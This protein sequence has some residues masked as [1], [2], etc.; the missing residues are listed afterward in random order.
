MKICLL[1]P[2]FPFPENGG[3]VL[4]LN[5]I[6]RYLKNKG[7]ELILISFCFGEIKL[8]KEYFDLYDTIYLVKKHKFSSYIFAVLFALCQRP[9]QCG[10]YFSA[11]FLG[12]L[13][14]TIKSEK[15]DEYIAHLLRM[16]PYLDKTGMKSKSI[17][18]MTDALSK[19]Y[20]LATQSKRRSIKQIVYRFER[21]LIKNYERKIIKTYPKVI[22][23]SQMDID[24][25]NNGFN[26]HEKSLHCYTNGVNIINNPTENYNPMKIC[27]IGNMRTLQN[28]D[29]VLYFIEEIFPLIKRSESN[30][31]FYIYGAEPPEKIQNLA[32]GKSIFVTGFV[33][34]IEY[35]IIDSCL[36]VAP[37]RIAAGIQNKVLVSM[38]CMIPVI[39][40][41]IISSAIP[42]LT[43]GINCFIKDS[44][45]EIAESCLE[46]MRNPE[47][48]KKIACAGYETVLHNY[49][50]D[51]K[52][53]GY[54]SLE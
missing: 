38:G 52:L 8:K 12:Q 9:A 2:R 7:H 21:N 50:W 5:S 14:K 27:F 24:Y 22:L 40:T 19:T 3:D 45:I 46:L 29:A 20:E 10:Y 51:K 28:Q 23:V 26:V 34:S 35:E 30:A 4:R 13:K 41:S 31:V 43:D 48:R 17:V 36:T 37:V 16:V 54:E 11:P 32:D 42:E 33:E 49:S 18:E 53:E 6:S 39:M 25:L 44:A 15:P 47:Y 1:A